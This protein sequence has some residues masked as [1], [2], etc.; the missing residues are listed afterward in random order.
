MCAQAKDAAVSFV[1]F[2]SH[3][4][5]PWLCTHTPIRRQSDSHSQH[6]RRVPCRWYRQGATASSVP[7]HEKI[8]DSVKVR[9]F[10]E[11][12]VHAGTPAHL[13]ETLLGLKAHVLEVLYLGLFENMFL[14]LMSIQGAMKSPATSVPRYKL[15]GRTD[16]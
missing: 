11:R 5:G 6:R 2:E 8:N 9:R 3:T 7:A 16:M 12:V 4:C 10:E 14:A 15:L 1:H 13:H